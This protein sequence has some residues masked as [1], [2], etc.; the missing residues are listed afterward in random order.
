MR[1]ISLSAEGGRARNM[2]QHLPPQSIATFDGEET[3]D[4]LTNGAVYALSAIPWTEGL[5]RAGRK[6][7]RIKAGRRVVNTTDKAA[8]GAL[9]GVLSTGDDR[10]SAMGLKTDCKAWKPA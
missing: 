9:E 3:T 6:V 2:R 1:Y 7:Q 4:R 10:Q 5:R 8:A